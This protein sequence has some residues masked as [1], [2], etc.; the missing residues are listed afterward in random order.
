MVFYGG[1]NHE[2]LGF[3][4]IPYLIVKGWSGDKVFNALRDAGKMQDKTNEFRND[5]TGYPNEGW[6]KKS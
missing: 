4:D 1:D 5:Y 2:T 6:L 3:T